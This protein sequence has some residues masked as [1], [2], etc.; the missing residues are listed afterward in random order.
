MRY[1]VRKSTIDDQE[2]V[3]TRI[4][5]LHVK[6][7]GMCRLRTDLVRRREW[8]AHV[9]EVASGLPWAATLACQVIAGAWPK[10]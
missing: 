7:N 3:R 4:H 6:Y 5:V 2:L 1:D 9:P 8:Q 10:Q